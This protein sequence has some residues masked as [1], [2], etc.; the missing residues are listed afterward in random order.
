MMFEYNT[1]LKSTLLIVEKYIGGHVST[2]V[3]VAGARLVEHMT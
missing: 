2:E 1:G 3:Y